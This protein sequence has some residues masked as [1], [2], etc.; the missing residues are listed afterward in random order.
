MTEKKDDKLEAYK[1]VVFG[2]GAVGKSSLTMRFVN[3][4][5]STEYLPTIED[6]YR[7][8]TY[9]DDKVASLDILDTAGQEDFASLRDGWVHEGNA[10]L[11]VYAVNSQQSFRELSQFRDRILLVSEDREVPVPMV[12][13]GNKADLTS[14]R[15]VSTEEGKA[16]AKEWNIPFVECSALKGTGCNEAFA[17][18]VRAIRKIEQP[19]KSSSSSSGSSSKGFFW[20][21]S[22]L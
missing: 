8:T 15:K 5:F 18:A 14:E 19:K 2:S 16:L 22:I 7:K 9:V 17:A 20:F 13:V 21:C 4:S 1:V 10:F 3:N 6:C 11:L 12:L